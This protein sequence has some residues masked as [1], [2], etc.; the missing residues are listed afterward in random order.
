MIP[1]IAIIL[2]PFF[3]III[4]SDALIEE[5]Q[6][7]ASMAHIHPSSVHLKTCLYI[8]FNKMD[9]WFVFIAI[10]FSFLNGSKEIGLAVIS[11][12]FLIL[13]SNLINKSNNC[14]FLLREIK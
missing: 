10:L 8:L 5:I 12:L 6:L 1:S 3:H 2:F 11:N 7:P 14:Y 4:R 9:M 13:L